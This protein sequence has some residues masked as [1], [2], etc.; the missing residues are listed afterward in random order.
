VV[1]LG[2]DPDAAHVGDALEVG[3]DDPNVANGSTVFGGFGLSTT[4]ASFPAEEHLSLLKSKPSMTT[5]HQHTNSLPSFSS[6]SPA[7]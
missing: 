5:G 7:L 6:G 4:S 1:H 3:H 2:V